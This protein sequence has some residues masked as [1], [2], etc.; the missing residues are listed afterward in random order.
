MNRITEDNE[1]DQRSRPAATGRGIAAVFATMNRAGT[2][3]SCVRALARQTRPPEWVVVADNVST[4]DTVTSLEGLSPLPFH[5]IVHRMPENRGNAGGVEAAMDLAFELG[6]GAVWILDDDSW[7]R[8]EALEELLAGDWNPGVVRHSV[9]V[10]PKSNRLTWPMQVRCGNG[11]HLVDDPAEL[12][13][14][15]FVK[16]RI[17][18]TGALVSKEVREV[19]GRVNAGLFIR[20][21]DEEYPWRIEKAGFTQEGAVKSVLDHPGPERLTRFR[22]LGRTIF[23][24]EG[25]AD[26]KL[27][28]KIR[29]M[30]WLKVRQSG[31]LGAIAMATAYAFVAMRIDGVRR[32]PLVVEASRDGL[33]GRLGKWRKH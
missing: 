30:V 25:L 26:W 11:F 32:L 8:R 33:V 22:L 5:L 16:T 4:D 17:M 15:G 31:W 28:Y 3:V 14:S 2:A 21:E 6:A 29:N 13:V 24:E 1:G 23:F 18:W 20:G 10:D 7:P 12:P 19:V 9:Q 27:H